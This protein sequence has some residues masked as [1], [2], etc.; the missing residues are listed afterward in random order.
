MEPSQVLYHMRGQTWYAPKDTK[1]WNDR[2]H[3]LVFIQHPA[4]CHGAEET[5]RGSISSC[6][7]LS[8]LSNTHPC[9]EPV[10]QLSLGI[11]QL[12]H[13]AGQPQGLVGQAWAAREEEAERGPTHSSCCSDLLP[14]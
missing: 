2:C 14:L 13:E 12:I 7:H 9:H 3:K 6:P 5:E 1:R 10:E 11:S 4:P 8:H